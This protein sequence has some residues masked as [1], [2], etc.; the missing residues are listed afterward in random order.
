MLKE[1]AKRGLSISMS[2][3]EFDTRE[4]ECKKTEV[5]SVSVFYRIK[6]H[7]NIL[8]GINKRLAGST[9]LAGLLL[10]CSTSFIT[11]YCLCGCVHTFPLQKHHAAVQYI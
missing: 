9:P 7:I 8:I 6:Y 2:H 4:N 3:R 5:V 10:L 11:C 1:A